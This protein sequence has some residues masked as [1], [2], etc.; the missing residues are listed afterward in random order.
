MFYG[1]TNIVGI[2]LLMDFDY[3]PGATVRLLNLPWEINGKVNA[4]KMTID[5]PV[6]KL[7]LTSFYENSATEGVRICEVHIEM[8]N[9]RNN[10][11]GLHKIGSAN[12]GRVYILYSSDDFNGLFGGSINLKSGWNFI[13]TYDNENWT[14]GADEPYTSIGFI[15]QNIN[16]VLEK[17]YRWQI[18]ILI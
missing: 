9:N 4:G 10:N 14:Y 17:D 7:E 12:N 16:D 2:P 15:T 11:F 18:E 6:R 13:E 8:K 5:F 1:N 3:F